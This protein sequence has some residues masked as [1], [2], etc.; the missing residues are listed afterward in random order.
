MHRHCA[1]AVLV[2]FLLPTA[3]SAQRI[4]DEMG[5]TRSRV[6]DERVQR[7]TEVMRLERML[8]S[9][10]TRMIRLERQRIRD[11]RM[12]AMTIAEAEATLKYAEAQLEETTYQ[13]DRGEASK[14]DV[15]RDQL[16]VIR[17]QGQLDTAKAAQQ[18]SLL[19]TEIDVA[20]AERRL[21][22]AQQE[23]QLTQRFAAKGYTTSDKLRMLVVEEKLARKE[24]DLYRVRLAAQKKS[25]GVSQESVDKDSDAGL[26][27]ADESSQTVVP[28]PAAD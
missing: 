12:P 10:E 23:L 28:V 13:L 24:L 16:A 20:Y 15:A 14:A 11:S 25:A 18:E 8:E 3:V 4:R 22:E 6:S 19:I 26:T 27:G 5:I 21:L 2:T 17:A 1:T 9:F 7:Q